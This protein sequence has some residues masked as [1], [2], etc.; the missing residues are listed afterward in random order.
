MFL[1]RRA[2]VVIFSVCMIIVGIVGLA[3]AH[4][5]GAGA[6]RYVADALIIAVS[7]YG[8]IGAVKLHHRNLLTFTFFLF[9]VWLYLI[10]NMVYQIV[11]LSP[12]DAIEDI[13]LAGLAFFCLLVSA[14][15][16][17]ATKEMYEHDAKLAGGYGG[18][19]YPAGGL[20]VV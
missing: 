18:Q 14:S 15:L 1:I 19:A 20:A 6:L 16:S 9:F 11:T 13:L 7:L 4:S 2:L 17:H 8:L 3:R 5:V 10:A 12:I